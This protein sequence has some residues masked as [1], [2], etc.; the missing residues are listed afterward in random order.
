MRNDDPDEA[1]EPAHRHRRGGAERR[2]D[3]HGQPQPGDVHAEAA[4][5]RLADPQHVEQPPVGQEQPPAMTTYG[6]ISVTSGHDASDRL[7]RIHV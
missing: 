7:P 3:H 1:D 4:R 6:R 5:F 2:R